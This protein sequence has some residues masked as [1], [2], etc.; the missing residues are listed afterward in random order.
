M[1][2]KKNF[3]SEAD[4]EAEEILQ[5]EETE[6]ASEASE[7]IPEEDQE[8]AAEET[9]TENAE[10]DSSEKEN[11]GSDRKEKGGFFGKGKKKADKEKQALLDKTAELEDRVRRQMAEF[12]NFRRRSDKEKEQMFTMGEK[13]ILEKILPIVDS[14]ELGLQGIPEDQLEEPLAQG[15]DKIYRQMLTALET[16]GVKPMNSVG[17]DFD[18]NYHNA[19]MQVDSEELESGKV[20]QEFQKGYL[21]K[22]T[23]LRHGMVSVVK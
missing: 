1:E 14:F 2:E 18:P 13:N 11:A 10:E 8:A 12:E 21:Y 6:E 22:D 17:E 9:E 7:E 3:D 20:A 5:E 4:Q 15:M 23:V 19:I 16:V